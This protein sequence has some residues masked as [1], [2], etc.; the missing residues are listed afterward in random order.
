MPCWLV[1]GHFEHNYSKMPSVKRNRTLR[2]LNDLELCTCLVWVT[3][4]SHLHC[5]TRS[6]FSRNLSHTLLV[7]LVYLGPGPFALNSTNFGGF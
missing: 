2:F 6:Y 7:S 5:A 1:E 4:L 3:Y